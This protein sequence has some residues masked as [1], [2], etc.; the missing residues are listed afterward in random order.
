MH[1]MMFSR[2]LGSGGRLKKRGMLP[3]AG[4]TAPDVSSEGNGVV[5]P[6]GISA[7]CLLSQRSRPV[8]VSSAEAG[9]RSGAC[10]RFITPSGSKQGLCN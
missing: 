5:S 6:L 7:S 1:L 4:V 2:L 3:L 10:P 9:D 8:S